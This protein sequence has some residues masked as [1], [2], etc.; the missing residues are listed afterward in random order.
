M[1]TLLIIRHAKSDHSDPGLNDFD[2]PL[3]ER[4]EKEAIALGKALEKA[5]LFPEFIWCSPAK[6]AKKTAEL[7]LRKRKSAPD[8][9]RFDNELYPGSGL[10]AMALLK[11]TPQNSHTVALIGHN[12][13]LESFLSS[14]ISRGDAMVRLTT[15]AAAVIDFSFDRWK[16]ICEDSGTLRLLLTGKL[17]KNLL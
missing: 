3:N 8:I 15:S 11:T 10:S 4:G 6:R 17:A 13:S 5:G 9:L 16:D 2:R 7:L 1:K 12:P 14:L